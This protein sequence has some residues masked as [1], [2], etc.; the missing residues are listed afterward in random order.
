MNKK[1]F[2]LVF[3]APDQELAKF[4]RIEADNLG[5][6][7]TILNAILDAPDI[8]KLTDNHK[9][10]DAV[11]SR[12]GTAASLEKMLSI[13]VISINFSLSDLL[14]QLTPYKTRY[15]KLV[16]ITYEKIAGIEYV[17]A[18]L[19]LSIEFHS[20]QNQADIARLLASYIP[21]QQLCIIGGVLVFQQ[22]QQRNFNTILLKTASES[23]REA[24][25]RA[26][27]V[28]KF[29]HDVQRKASRLNT[30]LSSVAEGV[31][32][33]DKFNRIELIN[34]IAEKI[35]K[36]THLNVI[37]KEISQLIPSSQTGLVIQ[38]K[39]A[40][41]GE[42]IEIGGKTYVVNRM[43]ILVNQECL[44]VICTLTEENKIKHAEYKLRKREATKRGFIAKYCFDDILTRNDN[45]EKCKLLATMYSATDAN[46]LLYGASGVGKELFA[47]SI[48]FASPR[49]HNPFIA[50][51]CAAIPENLLESELFGYEKGAFTGANKEGK[52]GLFELAHTGTLFLDEI[53]EMPLALQ[54]RL[55][56]ALQEKEIM[57]VG[58]SEVIPIDVRVISASNKNLTQEVV[59]E[60]FRQDL[61]YRLNHLFLRIPTLS[62]RPEDIAYLSE[63]FLAEHKID[64]DRLQY[65]ALLHYLKSYSW[66]GNVRE[67]KFMMQRLALMIGLFPQQSYLSLFK[68]FC[69]FEASESREQH[70]NQD[71]KSRTL[72]F[73]VALIKQCLAENN[74]DYQK[75]SQILNIS[76]MTVYRYLKQDINT[77]V[78]P[79]INV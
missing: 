31:I 1:M 54:A 36:N 10:Y 24:I 64:I 38:S 65:E 33:T 77:V 58:G 29:K 55:L 61:Y 18:A 16:L 59:K 47:N 79:D 43:P 70:S 8:S 48:H 74:Q 78:N 5:C 67:L 7:M 44:G 11:I 63:L 37:G 49:R 72:A 25:S 21:E 75:V 76:K 42:L 53:A 40:H 39:K 19:D 71:F 20:F 23:V 69:L 9:S 12:G 62:E 41:N 73:Q 28:S 15:K 52:T 13:P 27:S 50:I 22:A 45:M 51:N 3:V 30:I 17:A 68:S 66:Q 34:P 46:V 32:V 14:N 60:R 2:N 6:N 56:R 4:A 26:I 57:R 35:I